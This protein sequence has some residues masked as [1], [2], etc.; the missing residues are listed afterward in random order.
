MLKGKMWLGK[1]GKIPDRNFPLWF[2]L[3]RCWV[4][5]EGSGVLPQP[6]SAA[7]T[8]KEPG[9][10]LE[11]SVRHSLADS[12]TPI[13]SWAVTWTIL[14]HQHKSCA[15]VPRRECLNKKMP[16]C[17]SSRSVCK[18]KGLVQGRNEQLGSGAGPRN[19]SFSRAAALCPCEAAMEP[20]TNTPFFSSLTGWGSF[21]LVFCPSG[22]VTKSQ[23]TSCCPETVSFGC[24][25]F[26]LRFEW[27]FSPRLVKKLI[28]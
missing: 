19:V 16:L 25:S 28:F 18:R 23:E 14:L 21:E 2:L 6:R 24:C 20:Q 8:W 7:L 10:T 11:L 12:C 15:N 17:H 4:F 5:G 1:W 26:A 3:W 13:L 27:L 9:P 22:T